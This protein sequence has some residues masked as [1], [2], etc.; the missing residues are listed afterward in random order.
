LPNPA[1]RCSTHLKATNNAYKSIHTSTLQHIILETTIFI[2]HKTWISSTQQIDEH[3]LDYATEHKGKTDNNGLLLILPYIFLKQTHNSTSV[4]ACN[5]W[6][7]QQTVPLIYTGSFIHISN[8]TNRSKW[9]RGLRL[10]I[11][12]RIQP[13]AW[14][15]PVVSVVF[16]QLEVCAMGW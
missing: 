10:K 8:I 1:V 12:V 9:P 3:K 2:C 15:F 6:F 11:W 16:C 13:G 5:V 7:I 4:W 14:M